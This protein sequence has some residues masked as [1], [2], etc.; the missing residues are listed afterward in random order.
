MY[1]FVQ[2]GIIKAL[3][4]VAPKNDVRYY[5]NGIYVHCYAPKRV[6]LSATDGHV[7]LTTT[8][9][10]EGDIDVGES[11]II[12]LEAVKGALKGKQPEM[13]DITTSPAMNAIGTQLFT[14]VGGVFPDVTRVIPRK[15][16]VTK[17]SDGMQFNPEL[18]VKLYKGFK[19]AGYKV[20][21][22]SYAK[23]QRCGVVHS[24]DNRMIGVCMEM[25]VDD[26]DY[27]G[28]PLIPEQEAA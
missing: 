13:F 14:P 22:T 17:E 23:D 6:R 1:I 27:Y 20:P 11:V 19:L 7:L 4:G 15:G 3:A 8:I 18:L 16:G 9:N 25:R 5:L 12:P 10:V 24:E 28:I 26:Y 21:R 2:T